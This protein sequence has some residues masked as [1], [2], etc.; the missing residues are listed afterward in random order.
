MRQTGFEQHLSRPARQR[1]RPGQKQYGSGQRDHREVAQ[2]PCSSIAQHD[3]GDEAAEQGHQ[4]QQRHEGRAHGDEQPGRPGGPAGALTRPGNHLASAERDQRQQHERD[5]RAE[6]AGRDHSH[7][8]GEQRVGQR[9]PH[10][11]RHRR[12][13]PA[14]REHRAHRGERDAADEQNVDGEPR[15]AGQHG[16]EYGQDRQVR[17]RWRRRAEPGRVERLKVGAPQVGS[18]APRRDQRAAA[19]RACADERARG[20][21]RDH[22]RNEEGQ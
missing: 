12:G 14:N 11:G 8:D 21:D 20:D 6:P 18:A 16:G 17:G 10:P 9:C 7:R 3:R 4:P 5:S 15:L 13:D 22:N 2:Q 19:K 1:E